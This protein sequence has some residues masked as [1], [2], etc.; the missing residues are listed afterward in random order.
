M[1]RKIERKQP[2]LIGLGETRLQRIKGL[3]KRNIT[4]IRLAENGGVLALNG[5]RFKMKTVCNVEHITLG[6]L[7]IQHFH[8]KHTIKLEQGSK[9]TTKQNTIYDQISETHMQ[10][11]KNYS[12]G[13]FQ[14]PYQG[15]KQKT[16]EGRFKDIDS[17]S[18]E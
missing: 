6:R 9:G 4:Q 10:G 5:G 8:R 3:N 17:V 11:S 13:R 18:K 16:R 15:V 1:M 12:Y 7:S 2:D 14:L